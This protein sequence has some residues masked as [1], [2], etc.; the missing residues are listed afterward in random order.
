MQTVNQVRLALAVAAT[1]AFASPVFAQ[2]RSNDRYNVPPG[3][4]PPEGMC[5]VWIDG[6]PPGRQPAPTDC[7]TAIATRPANAH[8]IY[9]SRNNSFPGQGK[10]KWK[11]AQ[12]SSGD[13]DT[14]R[15]YPYGS[16]L[17]PDQRAAR[18]DRDDDGD[19]F[20]GRK[21]DDKGN[22][23]KDKHKNKSKHGDRNDND[24]DRDDR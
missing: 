11:N 9:G 16:V 18:R 8:V 14:R 2:G 21:D 15:T 3:Q 6:V 17:T 1:L 24:H 22:K 5:R 19:R 13:V 10:G 12:R 20:D 23:H 7:A 4:R